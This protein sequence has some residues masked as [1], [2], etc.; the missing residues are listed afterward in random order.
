VVAYQRSPLQRGAA[1]RSLDTQRRPDGVR[2]SKRACAAN[3][4]AI[5]QRLWR[6]GHRVHFFMPVYRLEHTNSGYASFTLRR[7]SDAPRAVINAA[8]VPPTITTRSHAFLP[9][10]AA[11]GAICVFSPVAHAAHNL[12][13]SQTLRLIHLPP[14]TATTLSSAQRVIALNVDVV[15][16]YDSEEWRRQGQKAC[17]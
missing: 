17:V 5:L 6:S 11:G 9:S 13:I 15:G 7:A 4:A 14:S 8:T 10:L 1:S 12:T 16:L 2:A 3:V